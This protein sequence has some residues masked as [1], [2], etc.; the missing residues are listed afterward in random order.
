MKSIMC[1]L[2][3]AGCVRVAA[4]AEFRIRFV[5]RVGSTDTVIAGNRLSIADGTPRRIRIQFGVFD[6]QRS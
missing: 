1:A 5:E 6:E 3:V 2:V 4:A